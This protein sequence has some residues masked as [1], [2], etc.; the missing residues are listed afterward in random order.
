MLAR[1]ALLFALL[2]ASTSILSGAWFGSAAQTTQNFGSEFV[3]QGVP[4]DANEIGNGVD[5][6]QLLEK[7]ISRMEAAPAG[8]LRVK[9]RQTINDGRSQFIAEGVLQRGPDQCAR[10]EMDVIRNDS[11]ARLTM[12]SDGGVF[13]K[14]LAMPNT[15]ESVAVEHLPPAEKTSKREDFLTR[16]GCGGPTALLRLLRTQMQAATL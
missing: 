2:T 6:A 4:L 10:L 5:A 11:R 7:A 12:V 13:A 3:P 16:H 9:F 14:V 15:A 1:T 8:W